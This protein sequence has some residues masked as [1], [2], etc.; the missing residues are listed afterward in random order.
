[1]LQSKEEDL[2][3]KVK[4]L[5]KNNTKEIATLKNMM[6][7]RKEHRALTIYNLANSKFQNALIIARQLL[8]TSQKIWKEFDDEFI[9]EF[10]ETFFF[11]TSKNK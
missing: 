6:D 3:K 2:A 10:E 11:R 7:R 8:F 1:M 9:E 4:F 5:K